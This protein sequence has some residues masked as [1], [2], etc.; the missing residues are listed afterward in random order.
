MEKSTITIEEAKQIIDSL[1]LQDKSSDK[2]IE[3]RAVVLNKI[4]S[5]HII[6][7]NENF[8]NASNNNNNNKLYSLSV[9]A[10]LL[11]TS[12]QHVKRIEDGAVKKIQVNMEND[13]DTSCNFISLFT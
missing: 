12:R 6:Q 13:E 8:L 4:L 5:N 2:M 9:I 3:K 1:S 11:N 10:Y 7:V